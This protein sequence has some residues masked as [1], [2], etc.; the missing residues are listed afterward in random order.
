M[1][2]PVS[3]AINNR[4]CN[5]QSTIAN[6]IVNL[7]SAIANHLVSLCDVCLRQNRQNLLNSNR[8]VVFFLF[9]VV[10]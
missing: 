9:L 5:R 6:A 2:S 8:S 1:Q 3:N 7:Q 10:L 4:Q